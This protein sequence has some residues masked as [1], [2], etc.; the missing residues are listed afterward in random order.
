MRVSAAEAQAMK[1][2]TDWA[3][4]DAM[5]DDDIAKAV[6]EDPDAAPLDIDWDK[7]SL[8][9][10][11]T[12]KDIITLRLDHD[13]LEWLRSTGKGYQT[14]INQVLRAWY[15]ASVGREKATNAG[16]KVRWRK[17][18]MRKPHRKISQPKSSARKPS[19]RRLSRQL[20][21]RQSA[22]RDRPQ[23]KRQPS[24]KPTLPPSAQPR[25]NDAHESGRP[26]I[27]R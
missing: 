22:P 12:A 11:A 13:V 18:V 14:R 23:R 17:P 2:Q 1:G 6:A 7:A 3:R 19:K 21:R 9:I 25:R 27:P 15:E 16:F 4:F 26:Q 5:T 24:K 8:V 20:L 10:P